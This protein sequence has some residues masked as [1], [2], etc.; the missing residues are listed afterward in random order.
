MP[1]LFQCEANT[2]MH[3]REKTFCFV[4]LNKPATAPFV[5]IVLRYAY[6]EPNIVWS[7]NNIMLVR[8]IVVVVWLLYVWRALSHSDTPSCI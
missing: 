2:W 7:L 5:Y 8:K 3:C 6:Y 4:G 1:S